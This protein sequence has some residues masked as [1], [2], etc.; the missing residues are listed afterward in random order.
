MRSSPG[1][2]KNSRRNPRDL[3]HS[4]RKRCAETQNP[5]AMAP[6]HNVPFPE[7]SVGVYQ[8]DRKP[9][10]RGGRR[11]G[12]PPA[13]G[14]CVPMVTCGDS[15]FSPSS[16]TQVGFKGAVWGHGA[17]APC[18]PYAAPVASMAIHSISLENF[19]SDT[20]PTC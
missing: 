3:S 17:V 2:T 5:H 20:L 1:L 14:F 19:Y 18:S 15:D 16:L 11:D 4:Q 13:V 7:P 9:C 8:L 10:P 6:G 12:L